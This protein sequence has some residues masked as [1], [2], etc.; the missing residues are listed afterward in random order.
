MFYALA[1]PPLRASAV[2]QTYDDYD[3]SSSHHGGGQHRY[4]GTIVNDLPFHRI[5]MALSPFVIFL[6]H[7]PPYSSLAIFL[8]DDFFYNLYYSLSDSSVNFIIQLANSVSDSF[9]IW[10]SLDVNS[11]STLLDDMRVF[12]NSYSSSAGN[13]TLCSLD[14]T[15]SRIGFTSDTS[16]SFTVPNAQTELNNLFSVDFGQSLWTF[17][18]MTKESFISSY[19]EITYPDTSH[20][21]K[22][23]KFT[24]NDLG[25]TY[26]LM[27]AH[28]TT[29]NYLQKSG[30]FYPYISGYFDSDVV[31]TN[32]SRFRFQT[33]NGS[34]SISIIHPKSFYS[35]GYRYCFYDSRQQPYH[36]DCVDGVYGF[37][38]DYDNSLYNGM[39]FDAYYKCFFWF[40]TR[41]GFVLPVSSSTSN[42]DDVPVY[43]PSIRDFPY[44]D[45]L[46][47]VRKQNLIDQ[48]DDDNNVH[49][50]VPGT[51][52]QVI[53]LI[54]D[55]S[56]ITNVTQASEIVPI[57]PHDLPRITQVP[58][59]WKTKFPFC[60]PYDV[61]NLFDSWEADA[62]T[63]VFHFL[64]FP[65]N[66]FGLNNEE[67]SI[68]VNF[69]DFSD[70]VVVL[71]YCIYFG[72]MA[73]LMF[74]S[75]K[76]LHH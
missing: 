2:T 25:F 29:S 45:N 41:C 36:I 26:L 67:V 39:T 43:S 46:F 49:V 57:Y 19:P 7:L 50:V 40:F 60:I 13:V 27:Y 17:G 32:V 24:I 12:L 15:S 65:A 74:A 48:A 58:Q 47:D 59:L 33:S 75:Y 51:W 18:G 64:V 20:D 5:E 76:F 42:T 21:C 1:V 38:N 8:G 62:E 22:I 9:S 37:Y 61:Y 69:D 31:V 14:R 6:C 11:V 16:F 72:F 54:N 30:T 34:S 68:V 3:Y 66:F 44:D 35:T 70:I 10:A 28:G 56:S 53:N 23:S 52:D 63:P 55:P 73:F 4:N 71:R